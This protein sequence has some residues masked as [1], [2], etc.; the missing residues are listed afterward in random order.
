[1]SST[2][3]RGARLLVA[4]LLA[5]ATLMT[6]GTAHA[7]STITVAPTTL[8]PGDTFTIDFTATPRRSGTNYAQRFYTEFGNPLGGLHDFTSVESCTGNLG[9]ACTEDGFGPLVPLGTLVGGTTYTGS[10]TLR[11]DDTVPSGSTFVVRYQLISTSVGGDATQD[12][13]TVTVLR[14]DA[15][16]AVGLS[17]T[18]SL[19]GGRIG[20][21]ASATNNGPG[22][23]AD[24]VLT[25]ELPAGTTSVASLPAGCLHTTADDRVTC[26]IPAVAGGATA[27]RSFTAQQGLLSVGLAL[28]VTT[29]RTASST[30]DP[31]AANDSASRN[32]TVITGLIILC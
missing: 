15:D 30:T 24:V 3:R 12:G 29:T 28:P 17:T 22:A 16:I 31:N 21:T 5:A 19:L 10:L 32:C 9:G 13:P 18:G 25:T 4:L 7:A 14:T 27:T 11:V 23:A 6:P 1:M 8:A 26:T 20:V 2:A